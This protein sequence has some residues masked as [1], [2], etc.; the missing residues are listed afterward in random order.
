VGTVEAALAVAE[1]VGVPIVLLG[2]GA[3]LLWKVLAMT[4]TRLI[5]AYRER[6]AALEA[7]RQHFRDRAEAHDDRAN[8][9][10]REL[11]DEARTRASREG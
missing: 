9:L 11:I 2:A 7:D 6:I 3:L 4:L 5:E 1:R 10:C 8:G